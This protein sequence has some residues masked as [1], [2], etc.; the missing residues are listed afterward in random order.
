MKM[1]NSAKSVFRK[2]YLLPLLSIFL[3]SQLAFVN[4]ETPGVG[5][6]KDP[7][8]P[9]SIPKF[10][11]PLPHFAG[12]RVN[13]RSGGN[14]IVK[15]VPHQQVALSTG[16]VLKNG[17]VIG[18]ADPTAGLGNYWTY[19][20]SKDGGSNWSP[21]LWPGVTVEAQRGKALNVEY[22]NELFGQTYGSVNLTVDQTIHWAMPEMTADPYSGPVPI[23]PHLHGGEVASE[24]DGGP[25]AWFT[26]GKAKVGP[27]WGIDGTDENYIYPNTQEEATLWFHDHA[28]GATRLN[29][30][31]GL[32]AYYFLRGPDEEKDKLPG[33]S[34]DDLVKEVA[35]AGTSG[36]FNPQPY[37][38]ELELAIQDRMFNEDGGLYWPMDPPNPNVHPYWTPEF[39]GNVMTVNGKSWPYLSVAPR[40]YRFRALCG[41]NARFL[42]MW[43]VD[44]NGANG[45]AIQIIGTDGGLLDSPVVKDPATGGRI[46]MGPGERMDLVIDFSTVAPGTV[47]TLMNDANIPYPD[48][49]AV[50]EGLDDRIMQFVV[51]GEKRSA[52]NP[53]S[54]GIDKSTVPASLRTT[55]LVKLTN[56]SGGTNVTPVKKRQ[57]TLNESSSEDGPL[58]ILVNNSHYDTNGMEM[59]DGAFGEVTEHPKEGTTELVTLIN[60]TMDTHPMHFHLVQFQLVSRQSFNMEGYD[61]AYDKA[62]QGGRYKAGFGPPLAYDTPNAD[63]A[64]GGNPAISSFLNGPVMLPLPEE[65]GWKDTYKVNPGEVATFLIR[66]AP[67]D[68]P[69]TAPVA[70]L[71]FGFDPSKGPGYVWH[72]HIVDHEDNEMMRPDWIEPAS[73]RNSQ[74]GLNVAGNVYTAPT[75]MSKYIWNIPAGG[76]VTAGGTTSDKSVTITWT[77]LG[78][79]L[80]KVYYTS[81]V[82]GNAYALNVPSTFGVNVNPMP[83]LTGPATVCAGSTGNVYTTDAGMSS[84][85]WNVSAGGVILAGGGAGDNTATVGWQSAGA[86][87]VGVTYTNK[88]GFRNSS[89]IVNNVTVNAQPVPTITGLATVCAG[90]TGV[91]YTTEVGMTGYVWSVSSGSVITSGAGTNSIAVSWNVGGSQIVSVNYTNAAGC[92]AKASTQ[93]SVTVNAI[94]PTPVVTVSG[95]NLSSSSSQ[96]NQWYFSDTATG[97]GTAI[98]GGTGQNYTPAQNGWY[99]TQVTV[100]G[101]LSSLSNKLYRLK[102][103]S[104]NVYKLF[105]VPNQGEFTLSLTTPDDE[106]FTILIYN[107]LGEKVYEMASLKVNGEYNKSINLRP[108]PT[109]IYSVVVKSSKGNVV[110][111]FTINQ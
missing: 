17:K 105:P 43:L 111:R 68:I 94:P 67:T 108:C 19:S 34:G 25:Y 76:T 87:T 22:R 10:V 73:S 15:A 51:N 48:G 84:Y 46:F 56:F 99:W 14:L 61:E 52:A 9:E 32:A 31:A 24:S 45:P 103:G 30:Y 88:S 106:V 85:T 91:V 110:K 63:G 83:V 39:Y 72:C 13:A 37:L 64:V 50:E 1:H 66:Y 59:A 53:A 7:I 71:R 12:L 28:M 11:D 109:G 42:N 60:T 77:S 95:V 57:L 40:K 27:T 78:E 6:G 44:Q 54:P 104:E 8:N 62:F 47:L 33:W 81:T 79:K 96:G 21:P 55:P 101:C 5:S 107:Q 92:S 20:I 100:N 18:S 65:R 70:D 97:S 29:V 69:V 23:V 2:K 80:L 38:P 16:T 36:T 58:E 75:G 35:P 3:L 26:P 74:V 86:Q 4:L 98:S 93:K 49:D 82:N 89:P 90:T 41:C 102:S